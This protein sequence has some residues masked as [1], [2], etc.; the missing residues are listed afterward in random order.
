[1][2]EKS[3]FW[4]CSRP[5]FRSIEIVELFDSRRNDTSN[6]AKVYRAMGN[7][8][9][10]LHEADTPENIRALIKELLDRD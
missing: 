1:M 9:L 5:E 7:E 6:L 4:L 8:I 10:V 2:L 3:L